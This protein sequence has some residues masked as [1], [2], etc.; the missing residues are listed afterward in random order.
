[1]SLKYPRCPIGASNRTMPSS[2]RPSLSHPTAT[3]LLPLFRQIHPTSLPGLNWN[4]SITAKKPRYPQDHPYLPRCRSTRSNKPLSLNYSSSVT[5]A[6]I[7]PHPSL[8][9]PCNRSSPS[10]HSQN[11]PRSLHIT[12]HTGPISWTPYSKASNRPCCLR[13]QCRL[14]SLSSLLRLQ[15][16]RMDRHWTSLKLYNY[17]LSTRLSR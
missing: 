1:M 14:R 16:M 15:R 3:C 9:Q 10:V 11:F 8:P 12:T 7:S 6:S 4:P 2:A 13:L 5:I 17:R